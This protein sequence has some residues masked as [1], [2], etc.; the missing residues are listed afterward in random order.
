MQK[1]LQDFDPAALK[2]LLAEKPSELFRLIA[3]LNDHI[4]VR[5]RQHQ[6]DIARIRCQ[7]Q[8]A[9]K[10]QANRKI[11][12][13]AMNLLVSEVY[14]QA[15]DSPMERLMRAY[16]IPFPEDKPEDAP[17]APETQETGGNAPVTEGKKVGRAVPCPPRRARS[18]RPTIQ[19]E[20]NATGVK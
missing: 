7:V 11:P 13:P 16:K 3:C 12:V 18:A 8:L 17:A 9:E 15:C 1:T 10:E 20:R 2:A 5:S 4:A 6:A 19:D 14:S